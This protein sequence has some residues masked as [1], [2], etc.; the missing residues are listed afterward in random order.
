LESKKE[1]YD[2]RVITQSKIEKLPTEARQ[3]IG[4]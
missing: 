1:G 4:Q 2:F 3:I